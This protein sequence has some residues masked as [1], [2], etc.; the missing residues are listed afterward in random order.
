MSGNAVCLARAAAV[1]SLL[2]LT[3]G[4]NAIV[5]PSKVD[6]NWRTY[7]SVHFALLVR[8]GSF[9]EAHQ[10]RLGEVL[11]DQYVTT[12]ARLGVVYEGRISAFLYD[13]AKHDELAPERDGKGYPDTETFK[14]TCAPPLDEY[15]FRLLAHEANHVIQW[16]AMGRPGSFFMSEGLASAV[17]STRVY[18]PGADA[19]WKWT[20]SQGAA[21]PALSGLIDDTDWTGSA[22]EVKARASTSFVAYLLERGGPAPIRQ[23][24]PVKSADLPERLRALYGGSLED[25]DRDWRAFCAARR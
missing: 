20:A 2:V 7:S 19:Y 6:H 9:A 12:L 24:Y 11:D 8:P 10:A 16:N 18:A 23:L 15:L 3:V 1:W 17:I 22:G 25:L 13:S 5:G 4:C 21:V 14:A